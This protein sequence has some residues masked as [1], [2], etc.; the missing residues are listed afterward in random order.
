MTDLD[1]R[2]R[3]ILFRATHRGTQET[4]RLVGGYVTPRLAGFTDAELDAIEAVMDL[5]D[6]DLADWLMGRLPI[7][8]GENAADAAGD[9]R[10]GVAPHRGAVMSPVTIH[11]A[12]EGYDALLLARRRAEHKGAVLHVTRDDTRMARLHEALTYFA[13]EYEVIRFP[14]WDCLPYDRVSPNPAIVSERIAA[15]ARLIEKSDTPRIVLTTVNALVQRVPPR[16]VFKGASLTVEVG[17]LVDPAEL[18]RFLEA[19]G[20]GRADTVMEPG[21]YAVRGGIV[22][23]YPAGEPDPVR[24]DLFGDTVESMRYFDASTQRSTEALSKL[25]FRPV[26]EIALD[27]ASIKRFRESWRELF[28]PGAASDP[29]YLSI[30]DGRRHPGMEHW[31]PLFH[32][33]MESLLDYLPDAA[34][35]LDNLWEDVL[36]ARGWR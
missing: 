19:N 31:A 3:R 34:V 36:G 29:I 30:S 27:A 6:V 21:E 24:L 25:A 28:G 18:T 23:V 26:S 11:G 13:P 14:A 5:P 15:L 22:D 9:S 2:R 1:A 35:S 17:G 20:Y 8:P 32:A 12:P 7:P 33:T 4:D 10:R 16:A